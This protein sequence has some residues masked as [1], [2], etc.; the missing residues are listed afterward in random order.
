MK[1][2]SRN[3]FARL[4]S[5]PASRTLIAVGCLVGTF[6]VWGFLGGAGQ[7]KEPASVPA[8]GGAAGIGSSASAKRDLI[9]NKATGVDKGKKSSLEENI[10]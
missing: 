7:Q 4:Y 2:S 3:L 6:S 5:H 9:L 10:L 1:E 8:A